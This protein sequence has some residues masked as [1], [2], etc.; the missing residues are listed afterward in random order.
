MAQITQ[1]TV[2][3]PA[4]GTVSETRIVPDGMSVVRVRA[5]V[6]SV[7]T[8]FTIEGS[9]DDGVTYDVLYVA[10]T[11]ATV[12]ASVGGTPRSFQYDPNFTRGLS[13]IRIKTNGSEVTDKDFEIILSS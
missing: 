12:S 8:S 5:P 4:G 9:V 3:I 1:T 11:G 6:M 7:A 13:R 10:G 2:T